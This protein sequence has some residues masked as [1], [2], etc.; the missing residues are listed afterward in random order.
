[1]D[2]LNHLICLIA[3]SNGDFIARQDDDDISYP[4]RIKTQVEILLNSNADFC[5]TR[6]LTKPEKNKIPGISYYFPIKVL[7]KFKNPFIHGRYC[8]KKKS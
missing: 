6:A 8:L 7:L 1:M 4:D 3:K 2:L 5:S